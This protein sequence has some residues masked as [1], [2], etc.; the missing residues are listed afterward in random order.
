MTRSVLLSRAL[1]WA[2]VVSIPAIVLAGSACDRNTSPYVPGEEPR[3]PDLSRIFPSTGEHDHAA[4]AQAAAAREPVAQQTSRAGSA[5]GPTISGE[6]VLA[7]DA[8]A[9][10]ML[11]VIARAKGARGGPPLAVLRVPGPSFPYAFEL[12]QANVM[13][14]SLRFEGEMDVTARLDADGNAMT[15]DATDLEGRAASAH[16][17]GDSGIVITL[18]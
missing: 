8:P 2:I 10:A 11:F 14:P 5:R 4:D 9:G 6:V 17:P 18:E 7:G 3:E 16:V 13:I 1:R 12:S 15:K